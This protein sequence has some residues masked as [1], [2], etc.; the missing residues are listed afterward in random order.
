MKEKIEFRL[1]NITLIQFYIK[2]D[3]SHK[4]INKEDID[5][6]IKIGMNADEKNNIINIDTLIG[7]VKR[8]ADNKDKVCELITRISY[9][10]KELEQFKDPDNK[11]II[12]PDVLVHTLFSISLS[13]TRGILSEKTRGTILENVYLPIL[14]PK[15]FVKQTA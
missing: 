1:D 15:K 7:M 6:D 10:V 3:L 2:N 8:N 5:F 12:I 14:D 13:T 11:E 9:E 4:K